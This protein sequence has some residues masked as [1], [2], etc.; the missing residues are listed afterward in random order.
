MICPRMTPVETGTVVGIFAE[1]KTH[2]LAVSLLEHH[3][4]SFKMIF[5]SSLHIVSILL[6]TN[7]G[8]EIFDNSHLYLE[9]YALVL[10][11]HI[12]IYKILFNDPSCGIGFLYF[13]KP[14]SGLSERYFFRLAKQACRQKRSPRKTKGLVLRTTTTS[15]MDSGT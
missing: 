15:M 8:L 10:K 7:Y 1:G 3:L 13:M 2:A 12:I 14:I 5:N 9:S 4:K 6:S 11:L